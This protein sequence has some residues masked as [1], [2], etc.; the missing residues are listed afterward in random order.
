MRIA[1]NRAV[2]NTLC[3]ML[4]YIENHQTQRVNERIIIIVGLNEF[5]I[6]INILLYLLLY[7]GM[8]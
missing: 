8:G 6:V 4:F 7:I 2:A 3:K 1:V 5:H